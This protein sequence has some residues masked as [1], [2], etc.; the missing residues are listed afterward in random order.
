YKFICENGG[1]VLTS[2][3]VKRIVVEDGK[4]TGV[5]LEDGRIFKAKNFVASSLDPHQTFLKLVDPATLDQGFVQRV[6]DW[7]WEEI[8]L[9]DVHLALTEPPRFKAAANNPE[10]NEAFIYLVGYESEAELI[11]HWN[12]IRRGELIA[13]GFNCCF[14]TVH[15]PSQAPKGRHTGLL[16]QHAPYNL[17]DGGG[18]KWYTA[19]REEH[20]QRCLEVLR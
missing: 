16:S 6:K 17:K 9:F 15:D 11:E 8:S 4:A 13:G 19:V 7:Q 14:P 20:A 1:R 10:L 12:A 3:L 5:E 18:E 2:Q